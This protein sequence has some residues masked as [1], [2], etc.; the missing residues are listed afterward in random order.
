MPVLR[1]V[2]IVDRVGNVILDTDELGAK[3]RT[4]RYFNP[5]EHI[6]VPLLAATVDGFVWVC[7]E[8]VWQVAGVAEAHTVVGG[9]SASV[10][11][12][13]CPGAVAIA[14]GTAQL[15]AGLDLT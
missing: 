4:G 12:T 11:V 1:N 7:F 9:A 2:T 15:T 5:Y 14:S 3:D 8:G 10:Q 13:V 6:T